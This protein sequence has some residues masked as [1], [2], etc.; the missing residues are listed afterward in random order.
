MNIVVKNLTDGSV[1]I[2]ENTC[3]EDIED[4]VDVMTKGIA[5]EIGGRVFVI[6]DKSDALKYNKS[7]YKVICDEDHELD[8]SYLVC[9]EDYY[10][11]NMMTEAEKEDL[12]SK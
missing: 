3:F 10:K 7:I 8:V 6:N 2:F 4:T 12:W 11:S 9:T 5:E 1:A